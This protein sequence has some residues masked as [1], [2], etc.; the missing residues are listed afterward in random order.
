MFPMFNARTPPEEARQ[1]EVLTNISQ[2]RK[3]IGLLKS[4][5]V[6]ISQARHVDALVDLQTHNV[7]LAG[8]LATRRTT[9]EQL[10]LMS[11]LSA[12]EMAKNKEVVLDLTIRRGTG[13]TVVEMPA[14]A[15]SVLDPGDVL[16]VR[17]RSRDDHAAVAA[18]LPAVNPDRRTRL[19]RIPWVLENENGKME[20]VLM[21]RSTKY[22]GQ[23]P[24]SAL[25]VRSVPGIAALLGLLVF[26]LPATLTAVLVWFSLGRPCCS[27]KFEAG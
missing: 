24:A 11:S 6:E 16:V 17:I 4:R 27:A 14:T 23:S 21:K 15:T 13:K 3:D 8:Y 10:V 19:T 26:A 22:R 7:D 12:A 5:L 18:A 25:H 1:L 20:A 2:A 9:E